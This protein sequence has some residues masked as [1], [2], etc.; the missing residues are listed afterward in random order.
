MR[1]EAPYSLGLTF[2][3]H[4]SLL[5][6]ALTIA[7]TTTSTAQASDRLET[8][9][10]ELASLRNDVQAISD[11]IDE[12]ESDAKS[13]LRSLRSRSADVDLEIQREELRKSQLSQNLLRL[14]ERLNEQDTFRETLKP[15]VLKGI[16]SLKAYV[17]TSLP[18]KRAER[19]AQLDALISQLNDGLLKADKAAARLWGAFEDEL[20]LTRETGLY[21]QVIQL[22]NDEILS[23][24]VRLGMMAMFYKTRDGRIGR[25]TQKGTSWQVESLS[26]EEDKKAVNTLFDA[27]KK[28][29]R[30]GYFTIPSFIPQEAQ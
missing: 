19:I 22:N 5:L 30:V 9:A 17:A 14:R 3:R 26:D 6:A 11:E 18:F 23:D 29:I 24:V 10:A 8:F 4:R 7:V 2:P 21:R 15:E 27:F 25:V 1:T 28:S 13:R 20:R 12:S 16:E